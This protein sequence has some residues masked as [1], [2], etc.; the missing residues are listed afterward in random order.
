MAYGDNGNTGGGNRGESARAAWVLVG[1][2][3]GTLV[4][5][6]LFLAVA[7]LAVVGG[8]SSLKVSTSD[9]KIGVIEVLG[10][11]DDAKKTIEQ[12][13]ELRDDDEIKAIV[14]RID[15]P[16]GAVGPSQEI[17][18]EIKRTREKKHVVCSLGSV[19]ASGGYYIA[20]ACE[21]IIGEPGTITGSI[22]VITQLM[23]MKE[24]LAWAKMTSVTYKSGELKDAGNPFRDPT[25]A[26][27]ALF[28]GLITD[29]YEQFVADVAAGRGLAVEAVRPVA[30]GR[31]L[32]GKQALEQKL[33]DQYGNLRDAALAAAS[34]AGVKGE[35]ELVYPDKDRSEVLREIFEGA[36]QAAAQGAV[37]GVAGGMQM[38][39][40][41][42][43]ILLMN[44]PGR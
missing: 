32:T 33:I 9:S 34:L 35:P 30:D 26:D 29:I 20:V 19:A 15:S 5:F 12:L 22:G 1:M 16:G 42:S 7:V 3:V 43:R 17:H 24:L 40:I 14:V 8:P 44:E 38:R 39:P 41:W 31:V 18:R 4:V 21:K 23:G 28:Q 11:I 36:A 13:V 2:L 27:A 6:T 25:E 37:G 10:P